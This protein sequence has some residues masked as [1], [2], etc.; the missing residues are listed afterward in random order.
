MEQTFFKRC[1]AALVLVATLL[2]LYSC[3]SEE[4][5]PEEPVSGVVAR[6]DFSMSLGGAPSTR[7]S[8]SAGRLD[9]QVGDKIV[10][11]SNGRLNGT[12]V[13]TEVADGGTAT[14]SGEITGFTPAGVNLY[15]FGN[16]EVDGMNPVFDLSLQ[17]GDPTTIAAY[18]FLKA[19]GVVLQ[20]GEDNTYAP[21]QPV[22]FEGMTAFLTV[23][24]NPAGS[25]GATDGTLATSFTI[26]GMKN[27]MS[28]NLADG[29]VTPTYAK[30]LLGDGEK[31]TTSVSPTSVAKYSNS[32]VIAVVPQQAA[33]VTMRVNYLNSDGSTE[34]TM[35]SGISWNMSEKAGKT[36]RTGWTGEGKVPTI[37]ETSSKSGYSGQAVEGGENADGQS[38]KNGYGGVTVGDQVDDPQGSKGGYTGTEVL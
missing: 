15:F 33:G 25:P 22:T 29:T 10:M 35:W 23:T 38:H 8:F 14:F 13:C 2:M 20:K 31:T 7:A 34:T 26:D 28:V 36:I 11:A 30:M 18:A 21:T 37:V 32:Y 1:P 12:L 16:K 17:N 6:A 19:T 24:L 3:T 4:F 9:W 27:C 5:T